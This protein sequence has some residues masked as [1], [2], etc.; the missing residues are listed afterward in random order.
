[1]DVKCCL[2][3][4]DQLADESRLFV[5]TIVNDLKR[6]AGKL[7][8]AWAAVIAVSARDNQ[9]CAYPNQGVDVGLV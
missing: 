9:V 6:H 1:M 3:R 5:Q 7:I 4:P 8:R 2:G